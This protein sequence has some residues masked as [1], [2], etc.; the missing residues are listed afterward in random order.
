MRYFLVEIPIDQ[1]GPIDLERATGTLR[2]AQSRSGRSSTAAR[3]LLAGIA[4][5]GGRLLCLIEAPT[6]RAAQALVGLALLPTGRTR[7]ISALTRP[8]ASARTWSR[9]SNG[10]DPG[11]DLGPGAEPELVEDVVDVSLHR[12]LGEE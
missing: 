3:A 7:E 6:A 12:A 10:S 2:T 11:C 1:V 4:E 8:A 9:S 5:D